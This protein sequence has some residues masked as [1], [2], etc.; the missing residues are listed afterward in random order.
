MKAG[1]L[2]DDGRVRDRLVWHAWSDDF[3]A[4]LRT[5]GFVIVDSA[6]PDRSAYVR[7]PPLGRVLAFYGAKGGV[8]T[9]TIAINAAIAVRT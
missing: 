2:G 6:A 5:L 1:R 9:T 7:R 8:G 3:V 4:R